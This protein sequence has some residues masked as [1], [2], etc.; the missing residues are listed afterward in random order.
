M[1]LVHRHLA[2]LLALAA[3]AWAPDARAQRL[4]TLRAP[5]LR[6]PVE[7]VRDSNGVAHIR[8]R[9][10]HDLF[11]A[12]GW[13]AARDRLFQLELWRRQATGTMA[14]AIGP[15]WASRDRAARLLAFRGDMREELA[16]YHPRGGPI[17]Q[18]F[19]DGINARIAQV[20][21]DSALLPPDLR[22]LGLRPG[23]WTPAVVVSRH[24][25]L[26]S[27]AEA[28]LDLAQAVR[29]MGAERVRLVGRFEPDPVVLEPDTAL[30]LA[31]LGDS[32]LA[33]LRRWRA[34]LEFTAGDLAA[35]PTRS[36]GAPGERLDGSNNWV[37]AGAR[38]KSGKPILAN[39]PHRA[40][41]VPSLRYFVHLTAPGWDV[42]GAGEPTLPG[43]SIG[44]NR[45]GAWGLTIFGLDVEDVY[46]YRTDPSDA[47][48]YRYR[49]GWSRMREVRDTVRVRGAGAEAVTLRFTR[50]GP[51]LWQ[52]TVRHLAYALRAAWLEPGTAPYLGSLRLDQA[53][54]W[55]EFRAGAARHLMPAEN[56]VWADTSGTIGWQ[57]AGIAP[58]RR[59]WTGLLPVPGDGRYEWRG[60][61]PIPQLPHEVNPR[62]GHLA[63]ANEN[64]VPPGYGRTDAVA[65]GD[66]AD[67]WRVRRIREVLD[68]T[69]E[70]TAAT[71]AALQ[72]DERSLPARALV[73]LLRTVTP[74]DPVARWARDTLLL[75]EHELAAR[76]VPAG[77]YVA[78]ERALLR[79][80]NERAVPEPARSHLRVGTTR[81]VEWLTRPE[82]APAGVFAGD[83]A[84]SR[85]SM[86][87]AALADGVASLR[88]RLGSDPRRW[89]YGQ[90]GYHHAMLRHPLSALLDSADRATFDAGPAPRGGSSHTVNATGGTDLQTHGASVR[91]VA[92]LADWDASLGTNT[93]GQSGDPRDAH[94]RDLFGAWGEGRY[95]RIP[96]TRAAVERAA[97]SRELLLPP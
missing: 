16:R 39:D 19:V 85:D 41:R 73:P 43:V 61:L 63:T 60:Y 59:G 80:V 93:P 20:E 48:R 81:L 70:A 13:N 55:A 29:L 30:D 92:D 7:I 96:Y 11:F 52:D 27:N 24:N 76:S 23:R 40:I 83:V 69:R 66:W 82:R 71:M 54:N 88:E 77:V 18:A 31:A 15:R 10:E 5:G 95:F 17:V 58:V 57:A 68:S 46:V 62:R 47:R 44:H 51:V 53:R 67:A 87:A 72:H 94:Y 12:Q 45:H 64:N 56:L 26:A 38:T 21:R 75:W 14:E 78:W 86:L 65:R 28:E 6:A 97:E 37:V 89:H 36:S 74:T 35:T 33:P 2:P 84:A 1:A 42:V 8:A 4:D 49:G 79:R 91:F 25:A 50:H 90:P 34:P 9:N 32:V 3:C 22:R